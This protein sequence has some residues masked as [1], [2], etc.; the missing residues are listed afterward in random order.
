MKITNIE[1]LNSAKQI[2]I[3]MRKNST[4]P[5]VIGIFDEMLKELDR[6]DPSTIYTPSYYSIYRLGYDLFKDLHPV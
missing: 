2:V 1:E 5:F 3:E 6:G 4:H